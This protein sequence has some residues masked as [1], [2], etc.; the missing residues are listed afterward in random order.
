MN[1][2]IASQNVIKQECGNSNIGDSGLGQ[3]RV[4]S[5]SL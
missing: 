3:L 1:E 5:R 2:I 4:S